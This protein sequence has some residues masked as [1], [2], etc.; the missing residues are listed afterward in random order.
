MP[1]LQYLKD[2]LAGSKEY[3]SP[4]ATERKGGE[5]NPLGMVKQGNILL[6]GKYLLFALDSHLWAKLKKTQAKPV[7][8]KVS[9]P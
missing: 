5:Q 2:F 7:L 4:E 1:V 9:L 3:P 8:H 6:Q